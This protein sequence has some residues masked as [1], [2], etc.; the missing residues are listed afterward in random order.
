[1]FEHVRAADW[2]PDG[3]EL[4]IVRRIDGRDHLEYP[5]GTTLFETTG[6]IS[7]PRVS[8]GG[9]SV[10][11]L[12]HPVYSDN[13]GWVALVTRDGRKKQLT[14]EW[15]EEDGLAWSPDGREVW[16]TASPSGRN[17][18]FGVTPEGAMRQIWSA[19]ADLTLLDVSADGRALVTTN[20]RR[21][22]ITWVTADDPRE[23]ILSWFSWTEP[24]D[25]SRDG[26]TIL[27]TRYDEGAG[28][29]YKFGL[30][31]V[32]A[33]SPVSL[34]AGQ[35]TQF[36]PDGQRVLAHT[37]VTPSLNVVPTGAGE[38]QSLTTPG[39]RYF[40][41]G[42]F[43]DGRRVLFIGAHDDE[44]AAAY[45]QDLNGAPPR[46][47]A[48]APASIETNFG[49]HISPDR[50]WFFGVQSAGPPTVVPI[51]GGQPRGLPGLGEGD[52]PAA[53]SADSRGMVIARRNTDQSTLTVVRYDVATARTEPIRQIRIADTSGIFGVD[54]L[55]TPDGRTMVYN[56]GRFFTDLY[57]VEG[58][59]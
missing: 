48:V 10:A 50:K 3:S 41:G 57:L 12:E 47:V 55:A 34:G 26:R 9:D 23:R 13:R 16:F 39:F 21:S 20:A 6:Y 46:R 37:F 35:S 43:P 5:V 8:P 36:S 44:P 19:P 59:Q 25:I 31:S 30:R 11:C 2:S 54:L 28:L 45:E 1:M 56:V 42:W 18:L 22:S 38:R 32:D 24:N 52:T 27:L 4:A 49:L 17:L 7:H 33:A 15:S 29:D 14:Q 53:W 40:T 58:L 51:G